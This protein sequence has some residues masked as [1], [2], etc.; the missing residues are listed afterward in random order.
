MLEQM[1]ASKEYRH[2]FIEEAIRSR[3]V[4]Q[5]A[6]L[7]K[8]REWD[9]KTFAAQIGKKVSWAYRLEDP[10][11]AAPTIP[12]LLEVAETYDVGLDVRFRPFSELLD[13]VTNL[14]AESFLV[15]SFTVELQAGAFWN[16]RKRKSGRQPKEKRSGRGSSL[17]RRTKNIE[18]KPPAKELLPRGGRI[19]KQAGGGGWVIGTPNQGMQ[20]SRDLTNSGN[21]AFTGSQTVPNAG[22]NVAPFSGN[23]GTGNISVPNWT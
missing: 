5:I 19:E 6:A 13:D 15:P 12:S 10:N 16:Q 7:R 11:A 2:G 1:K 14:T 17:G 18:K 4:G 9:L 8:G 21:N 22:E 23:A 3:I 20:Q